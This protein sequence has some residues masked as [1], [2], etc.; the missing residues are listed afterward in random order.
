MSQYPYEQS[1][2]PVPQQPRKKKGPLFWVLLLL[3]VVVVF[4]VLCCGVI[5][6]FAWRGYSDASGPAQQFLQRVQAEEYGEIYAN[7]APALTEDVTEEELV[8]IF[9]EITA[10]AGELQS[11]TQTNFNINANM[12]SIPQAEFFYTAQ[13]SNGATDVEVVLHMVNDEWQLAGFNFDLDPFAEATDESG[14]EV[15]AE[16]PAEQQ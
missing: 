1:G 2:A 7:A 10:A 6:L 3:G 8:E 11:W 15:P 4:S 12:G 13:F 14:A 5:G 16:E 9:G